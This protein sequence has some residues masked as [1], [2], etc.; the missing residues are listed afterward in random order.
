[1][2]PAEV[3]GF[4]VTDYTSAEWQKEITDAFAMVGTQDKSKLTPEENQLMEGLKHI[5]WLAFMGGFHWG[6]GAWWKDADGIHYE[7][8]IQ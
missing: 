8:R 6:A 4:S 3:L 1:L 7:S 2:F 5:P